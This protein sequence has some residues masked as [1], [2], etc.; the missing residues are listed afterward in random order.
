MNISKIKSNKNKININQGSKY[1]LLNM[2]MKFFQCF[3]Q[4]KMLNHKIN[5]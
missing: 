2:L 1:N 3:Y 5:N 4:Q